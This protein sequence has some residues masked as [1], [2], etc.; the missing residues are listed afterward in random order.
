MKDDI[1]KQI[2]D[3]KFSSLFDYIPLEIQAG[4][5]SAQRGE[6]YK[7]QP[8]ASE[9]GEGSEVCEEER[10]KDSDRWLF[11]IATA[12]DPHTSGIRPVGRNSE[13]WKVSYRS[14]FLADKVF[15][16]PRRNYC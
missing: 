12:K 4:I 15:S 2:N 6:I 3:M 1:K 16:L 9:G 10:F 5:V 13:R 8:W 7:C 14:I 11:Y